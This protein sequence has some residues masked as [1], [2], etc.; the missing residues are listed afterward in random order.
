MLIISPFIASFYIILLTYQPN[1]PVN[2]FNAIIVLYKDETVRQQQIK[3]A[4]GQSIPWHSSV[5]VS[6]TGSSSP[7]IKI[8]T[9]PIFDFR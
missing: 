6:E 2:D 5:T 1:D 9:V 8:I 4:A 7:K 3:E